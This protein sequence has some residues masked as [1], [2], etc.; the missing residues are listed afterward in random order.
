MDY[1]MTPI[2]QALKLTQKTS[3]LYQAH[4]TKDWYQ[5][6]GVY[7]GIQLGLMLKAAETFIDNDDFVPRSMTCHYCEPATEGPVDVRV[8]MLRAGK[9][10]S[11]LQVFIERDD[12]I[13]S[14]S[15]MSWGRQRDMEAVHT[16]DDQRTLPSKKDILKV[17]HVDRMP[18]FCQYVQFYLESMS[19]PYLGMGEPSIKGYCEFIESSPLTFP[20]LGAMLDM[21]WPSGGALLKKPPRNAGTIDLSI[22]FLRAPTPEDDCIYMDF[23]N[24]W[25]R[26]GYSGEYG[27][28]YNLK[29][30]KIASIRQ[31]IFFDERPPHPNKD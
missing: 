25:Q 18:V 29:G 20:V 8:Q 24:H 4:F 23:E 17:P 13:I 12:Q 28:A 15:L 7:G 2:D 9:T 3:S 1:C 10:I 19:P 31:W 16:P 14:S 21:W 26:D 22:H 30:E 5:G 11:H 6:R 27:H